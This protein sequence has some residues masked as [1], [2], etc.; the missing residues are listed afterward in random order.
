MRLSIANL[1][2]IVSIASLWSIGNLLVIHPNRVRAS[3]DVLFDCSR[4]PKTKTYSTVVKYA[5]GKT[6]ELIHWT[7]EHIKNPKTTCRQVSDKFQQSWESGKLNYLKTGRSP[8]T[9]RFIICGLAD[10]NTPCDD[11]NK[12]FDLLPSSKD[13]KVAVRS[14]LQSIYQDTNNPLYQS[15]DNEV[16][17]DLREWLRTRGSL[18][19]EIAPR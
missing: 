13:P 10:N 3:S 2:Q 17:I 11:R 19:I 8:K 15:S 12:I 14:L 18:G 7:P 4:N 1:A 16:T 5:N 6:S 9:G